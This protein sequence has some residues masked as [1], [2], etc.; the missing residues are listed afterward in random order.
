MRGILLG[1]SLLAAGLVSAAVLAAPGQ[2]DA[3]SFD[4]SRAR[5]ASEQAI[6][7]NRS[8]E[9]RDVKMATLYSVVRQFQGGMGYTWENRVSRAYR[10]YR[11]GSMGG[12][13][14]EVMLMVIARKMGL[15]DFSV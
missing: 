13:A 10:D 14:D 3:A 2:A 6:C 12:G 5:T 1:S 15:M 7:G 9:D 11:L 4:C 8:L